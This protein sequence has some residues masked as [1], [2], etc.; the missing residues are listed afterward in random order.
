MTVVAT[1]ASNR[2]LDDH[3]DREIA[4]CLDLSN[5]RSFFLFAG[6]GSGK[7]RSLVN[8]LKH[9]RTHFGKRLRFGGQRIAVITYTN[10]ACDEIVQRMDFDPLVQVSTIH[11][12]AWQL[13]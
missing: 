4:A 10:A 13:I 7:T 5:P 1:E 11:S 8:A 9:L 12:F 2:T 3:V 6:A